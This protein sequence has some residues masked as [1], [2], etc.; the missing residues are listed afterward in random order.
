M[1][2]AV[3]FVLML[4]P[5]G[6]LMALFGLSVSAIFNVLLFILKYLWPGLILAGIYVARHYD[7]METGNIVKEGPALELLNDDAV[8]NAYL[9]D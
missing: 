5:I 1:I 3:L 8:K 6:I 2:I 9:G 4:I 7:D